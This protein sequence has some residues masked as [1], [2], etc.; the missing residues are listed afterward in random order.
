MDPKISIIIRTFNEERWISHCLQSIFS[1]NYKNIE[2][3]IVDNNS[4]DNT[5]PIAM[6]H[7]VKVISIMISSPVRLLMTVLR[8]RVE[9]IL[10]VFQLIVFL[11]ILSG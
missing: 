4:T 7:S 1:Q 10:L 3:I 5:L 11:Q 8:L 9:N 6:R 2:V